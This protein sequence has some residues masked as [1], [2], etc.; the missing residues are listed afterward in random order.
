MF[1]QSIMVLATAIAPNTQIYFVANNMPLP[2]FHV[3]GLLEISIP[4]HEET[5]VAVH[6]QVIGDTGALNTLMK[7]PSALILGIAV[8][9]EAGTVEKQNFFPIGTS[10]P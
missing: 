4:P 1:S 3:D 6:S 9:T 8:S 7:G 5:I 10:R 2:S